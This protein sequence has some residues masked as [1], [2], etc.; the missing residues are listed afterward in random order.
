MGITR[1]ET[2]KY[3]RIT[4]E[5]AEY[6]QIILEINGNTEV[7]RSYNQLLWKMYKILTDLLPITC[8]S[9]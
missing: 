6:T 5:M 8:P 4:T 7:S 9:L 3:N 1:I 2:Q